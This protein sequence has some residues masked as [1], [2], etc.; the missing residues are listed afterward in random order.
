MKKPSLPFADSIPAFFET[1]IACGRQLCWRSVQQRKLAFSLHFPYSHRKARGHAKEPAQN[2]RKPSVSRWTQRKARRP[3]HG[4]LP[5]IPFLSSARSQPPVDTA[6]TKREQIVRKTPAVPTQKKNAFFWRCLT[7]GGRGRG[8]YGGYASGA[9]SSGC[10]FGRRASRNASLWDS[11]RPCAQARPKASFPIMVC[12]RE[13]APS[14]SAASAG[15]KAPLQCS[16]R[17]STAPSR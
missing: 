16:R 10:P 14:N 17:P 8:G 5:T 11:V 9:A 2:S 1:L 15:G 7:G 12:A 4:G 6:P 13:A 3:A